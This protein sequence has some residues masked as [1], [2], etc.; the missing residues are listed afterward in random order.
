MKNNNKKKYDHK[1]YTKVINKI[2]Q[3]LKGKNQRNYINNEKWQKRI[4]NYNRIQKP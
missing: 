1:K 2:K 4:R 3:N